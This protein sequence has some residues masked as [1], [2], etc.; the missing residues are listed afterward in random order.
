[1]QMQQRK[2][3]K[4]LSFNIG[5]PDIETPE[6]MLNAIKNSNIHVI[7][8]SPSAGFESYRTKLAAY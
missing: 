4:N 6:V 2:E 1:M 5:Q 3:E 8:Y 7:E